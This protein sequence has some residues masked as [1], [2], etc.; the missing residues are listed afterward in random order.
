MKNILIADDS[1]FVRKIVKVVLKFNNFNVICAVNGK[2]AWII[3][4]KEKIDIVI[5]GAIMPIMSGFALLEKM[6]KD[7]NLK[8][9]PS[10]V[11]FGIGCEERIKQK[12]KELGA[13]YCLEKP[14]QPYELLAKVESL[15][16][17]GGNAN[18]ARMSES[19]SASDRT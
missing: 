6:K 2:E 10:I 19:K 16:Q 5:L 1:S 4:E 18:I 17:T 13:D 7:D 11:L 8:N 3:M 12:V 15:V 14:L 9:I